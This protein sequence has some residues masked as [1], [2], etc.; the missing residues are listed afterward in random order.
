MIVKQEDGFETQVQYFQAGCQDRVFLPE[1][2][3]SILGQELENTSQ[4]NM[5][6]KAGC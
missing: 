5:G 6:N 2:L 1:W 4:K 3:W